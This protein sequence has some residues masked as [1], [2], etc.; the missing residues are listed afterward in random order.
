M[1]T[2]ALGPSNAPDD[3][4]LETPD[5]ILGAD[6]STGARHVHCIIPSLILVYH[7]C[8]SIAMAPNLHWQHPCASS[9]HS[10]G[11]YG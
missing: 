2:D 6:L 1:A 3:D 7:S 10:C 5:K 11:V 8:G 4:G 9:S